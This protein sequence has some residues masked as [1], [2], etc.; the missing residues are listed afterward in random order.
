MKVQFHEGV[1][2]RVSL[3]YCTY[4]MQ[5]VGGLSVE[6]VMPRDSYYHIVVVVSSQGENLEVKHYRG[7]NQI[8]SQKVTIIRKSS[9]K[10]LHLL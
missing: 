3:L 6:F 2:C 4:H 5:L 8:E 1:H 9:K 7:E 10:Y